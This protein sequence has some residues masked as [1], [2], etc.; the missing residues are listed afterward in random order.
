MKKL[1]LRHVMTSVGW[2]LLGLSPFCVSAGEVHVAAA[3]NFRAPLEKIA[4]PFTQATGHK[5]IISY[6]ATG[7]FYAQIMNGAPFEVF[8]AADQEHPKKLAQ[9]QPALAETEF[10][11]AIGKLVLWGPNP[12]GVDRPADILEKGQ[13]NHL[14]IAN[15]RLAPYG[16]AAKQVLEKMGLWDKDESRIVLGENITQA[17]QF[18]ATGNAELG[19]VALSQIKQEGKNPEGSFWIVPGSMYSPIKQDAVLLEKGKDSPA[20]KQ[21]LQFL[22][23]DKAKKIIEKYGYEL[24]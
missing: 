23:S 14:S 22:K 13:F 18:V 12:K 19:F 15:P 6:G 17:H 1:F 11:Y 20:A 9:G 21:F 2:A 5:L 4:T 10:T 3:S 7:K 8:L 16:K 24:P